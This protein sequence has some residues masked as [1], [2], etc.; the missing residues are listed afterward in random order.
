MDTK[1]TPMLCYSAVM[2]R[3]L[4]RLAGPEGHIDIVFWSTDAWSNNILEYH[5][6]IHYFSSILLYIDL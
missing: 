2:R 6:D 1:G 4:P 3:E 5:N